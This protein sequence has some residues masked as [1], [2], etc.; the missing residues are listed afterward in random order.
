MS[1]LIEYVSQKVLE[2]ELTSK[3]FKF[4][5]MK[6]FVPDEYYKSF[7]SV[8]PKLDLYKPLMYRSTLKNGSPTRFEL[9]LSLEKDS[10]DLSSIF[11]GS[12]AAID[13]IETLCSERFKSLLLDKFGSTLDVAPYPHLYKDLAGFNLPP[14][15]D[16]VEKAITFGWYLP[17]DEKYRESGLG[18]FIKTENEFKEFKKIHYRPNAAFAFLR[19]NDSWHG[20]THNPS[21]P[22]ERN[23]LFVT[24]YRKNY[25]RDGALLVNDPNVDRKEIKIYEY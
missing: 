19:S 5:E 17:E 13:I 10:I 25:Y 16:I 8:L 3:P 22:Y 20:A 11:S 12:E 4:F 7:I 9:S 14:H 24:F 21:V 6:D 1:G 15:T 18:L 2:A 23:S